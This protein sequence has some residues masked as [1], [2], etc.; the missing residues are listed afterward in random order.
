MFPRVWASSVPGRVKNAPSI[1]IKLKEGK[2]P[3]RIKQYLLKKEAR[4]EI[5]PIIENFLQLELLKE[6]RSD[7]NTLILPVQK[8]NRSYWVVQDCIQAQ[9]WMQATTALIIRERSE[10]TSI[11]I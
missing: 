9:L 3:V 10:G 2:Q 1:I 11:E 6:C 7:F 5:S 4:E 8:P